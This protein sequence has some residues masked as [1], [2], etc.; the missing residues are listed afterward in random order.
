M[1][2]RRCPA[3]AAGFFRLHRQK[4]ETAKKY[5]ESS[6]KIRKNALTAAF[7]EFSPL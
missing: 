7:I 6:L 2:N 4:S 1:A 5:R 3:E